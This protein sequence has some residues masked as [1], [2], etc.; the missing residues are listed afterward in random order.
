M[1]IRKL[2]LMPVNSSKC[3]CCAVDHKPEQPHNAQSLYYGFW[4][5]EKYGRSPTWADAMAHCPEGIKKG[6]TEYLEKLGVDINSTNLVGDLKCRG[7]IEFRLNPQ[8]VVEKLNSL[9]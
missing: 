7:D 2:S 3:Q 4:H 5:Q 8:K 6:F 1:E 9:I